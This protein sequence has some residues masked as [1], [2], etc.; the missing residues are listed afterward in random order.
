MRDGFSRLLKKSAFS[1]EIGRELEEMAPG[2][3]LQARL[4]AFRHSFFCFPEA[5]SASR[6]R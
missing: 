1:K 4:L 3:I 2:A 6:D 5:F